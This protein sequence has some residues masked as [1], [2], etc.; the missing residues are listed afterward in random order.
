MNS[1]MRLAFAISTMFGAAA[2]VGAADAQQGQ[3]P[4]PPAAA[5]APTNAQPSAP[6]AQQAAPWQAGPRADAARQR[7]GMLARLARMQPADRAALIDAHIAALKAGLELTPDQQKL[8]GPVESA[9]RNSIGQALSMR[10]RLAQEARPTDPMQRLSRLS[11]IASARA[12]ALKQFV[13]AA[14]PL[15]ASLTPDQKRR[16]PMLMGMMGGAGA[17]GPG[18]PRMQEPRGPAAMGP[19]RGGPPE[20]GSGPHGPRMG[21]MGPGG[22]EQTWR[23]RMGQRMQEMY[24]NRDEWRGD[25]R[26][27]YRHGDQ[28]SEGDRYR[29]GDQRRE[30]DQWGDRNDRQPYSGDNGD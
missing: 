8:W 27:Q 18:G 20:R 12:A 30:G 2:L 19:E 11:E 9:M 17:M 29:S 7:Q 22:A 24:R 3:S 26:D 1:R 6:A 4:P 5:P 16:I 21:Q 28:R 10:G 14:Q 13:D 15:Y 25:W 23:Q